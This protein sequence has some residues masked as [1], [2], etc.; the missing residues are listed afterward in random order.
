MPWD[1]MLINTAHAP[2]TSAS[3]TWLEAAIGDD[4]D[5]RGG[6]GCSSLCLDS[7]QQRVETAKCCAWSFTAASA[8]GKIGITLSSD[9]KSVSHFPWILSAEKAKCAMAAHWI[10]I[11]SSHI[12]ESNWTDTA[13]KSGSK[14]VD[15]AVFERDVLVE[16]VTEKD[17]NGSA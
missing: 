16:N 5:G 9:G 10:M 11:T 6:E 8:T 1:S 2:A 15:I 17:A 3:A 14:T 4:A 7:S 12:G 13:P